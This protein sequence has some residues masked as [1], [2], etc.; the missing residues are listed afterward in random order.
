MTTGAWGQ[1]EYGDADAMDGD[2]QIT[3]A[4]RYAR[5]VGVRHFTSQ[6]ALNLATGML[7]GYVAVVDTIPGALFVYDGTAWQMFGIPRFATATA[8]DAAITAPLAGWLS[9]VTAEMFN[10]LYQGSAWRPEPERFAKVPSSVVNGTP[11]AG[12]LITSTAQSTVSVNDVFDADADD[13]VMI[14]DV[15]LSSSSAVSY[16][17][18][19]S[20]TDAATGYDTQRLI[21]LGTSVQGIQALND[22]QGLTTGIGTAGRHVFEM[23]ISKP[24]LAKETLVLPVGISTPNPMTVSQGLTVIG[25]QHRTATAYSGLTLLVSSGTLIV[26]SLRFEALNRN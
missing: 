6:A 12:G 9:R 25:G 1:P 4:S 19:A 17:L 16:R 7:T 21:A 14:A 20:G 8:R 18:R 11:S 24:A 26:N 22:V 2:N 10:R 3:A 13:Y 5:D 23:L 15:T